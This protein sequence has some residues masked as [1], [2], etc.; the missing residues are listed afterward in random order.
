MIVELAV[1]GG[2]IV[3][4]VLKSEGKV[5]QQK[6]DAKVTSLTINAG[7]VDAR[8]FSPQ[9]LSQLTLVANETQILVWKIEGNDVRAELIVP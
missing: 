4:T 2:P 6:R 1:D 9:E 7:T 8:S 5:W 3:S